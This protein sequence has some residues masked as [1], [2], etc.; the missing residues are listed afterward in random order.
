[1]IAFLFV[2]VVQ[3]EQLRI[4][5]V[6]EPPCVFKNEKDEI[7]GLAVDVVNAIQHRINSHIPIEMIPEV[8]SLEIASRLS[9]II[10]LGF[11]R[12]PEREDRFY[13]ITK[14]LNKSW[15]LYA[16]KGSRLMINNLEDARK[17]D[18]IGV[19]LGDVRS[20]YLIRKGFS[21]LDHVAHHEQNIRKVW[22]DRISM[23]YYETL[24]M[25][26]VCER[27]GVPL[28]DFE[29]K[30]WTGSSE[31]YILM[32]RNGTQ[33]KTAREWHDAANQLKMDGTFQ[34]IAEKWAD[35]VYDKFGIRCDVKDSILH[36]D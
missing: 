28:S 7:V 11:S 18:S 5:G 20:S 31:V 8:R 33:E 12:T 30:L 10:L 15:V 17:V 24:G 35:A 2:T 9:N 22:S 16:K 19:V 3:A 4:V 36:F 32:S 34:R 27:L 23:I 29:A 26:Y 13:W 1:M 14:L 21:N 25:A 6:E